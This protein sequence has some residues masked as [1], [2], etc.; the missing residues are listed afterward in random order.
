MLGGE[1]KLAEKGAEIF[2]FTRTGPVTIEEANNLVGVLIRVTN[3]YS[4]RV[5]DLLTRLEGCDSKDRVLTSK[6]EAEINQL[7]EEWNSQVRKLRGVPKGLWLV[8]IDAGDGYYCWKYPE[9]QIGY[10]HEY[11]SGYSGRIPISER[12][13]RSQVNFNSKVEEAGVI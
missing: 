9:T 11:K 2:D 7:I 13:K 8:D 3:K 1:N 10:W 6:L 12:A 4:K 5:N